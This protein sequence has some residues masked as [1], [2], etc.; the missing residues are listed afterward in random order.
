M[1]EKLKEP[2]FHLLTEAAESY[3]NEGIR[4][5]VARNNFLIHI[6]PLIEYAVSRFAAVYGLQQKKEDILGFVNLK[7][8]ESWLPSYLRRRREQKETI[9]YFWTSVRGYV[10]V[11]VRDNYDPRVMPFKISTE[12]KDRF[13]EKEDRAAVNDLKNRLYDTHMAMRTGKE[14]DTVVVSRLAR[15]L[16]WKRYSES[17]GVLS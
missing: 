12:Y 17:D 16:A 3:R 1:S 6:Q 14:V 13:A 8:L 5:E 15:H 11:Y 10:L 4:D 7:M 9:R 2:L